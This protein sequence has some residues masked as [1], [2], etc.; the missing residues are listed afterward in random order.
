MTAPLSRTV[1]EKEAVSSWPG[2][3]HAYRPSEEK[4]EREAPSEYRQG[5][6]HGKS[7]SAIKIWQE[8]SVTS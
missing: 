3:H 8:F 5:L 6:S 2:K 7:C 4:T 1:K